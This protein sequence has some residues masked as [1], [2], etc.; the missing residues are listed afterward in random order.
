[1]Q[2]ISDPAEMRQWSRTQRA[3][4]HTIGLVPTMG[5]LHEGHLRL[6][7]NART[8]ADLVVVSVF[9]NPTQFGPGEDYSTY[10]RDLERDRELIRDRGGQC[11]FAPETAD[12][13]GS[14]P[15]VMVRA[16]R[17]A[18]HLCGPHRAGHFDGVLTIVAKLFNVVEPDVAVFGRKDAQQARI[19]ARMVEDLDFP[20]EVA[21]APTVRERDL[22]AMSSRN[23]YL[24]PDERTAARAIPRSLAQAHSLF[25]EGKTDSASLTASIRSVLG[26]EP[27]VD[28]EYVEAVDPDSLSPVTTADSD[29]IVA[30][31]VRLGKARLIDNIILGAGV[32]ADEVVG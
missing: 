29:T 18:D 13:Y 15:V 17:L 21:V 27:L 19:I 3:A 14:D 24:T 23:T 2:L 6:I 4:G 16:G 11:V 1:M 10:P 8:K 30:L 7:D 32:E 22:V 9:V 26:E 25:L 12:M 31:A 20:T 28:I 5:F